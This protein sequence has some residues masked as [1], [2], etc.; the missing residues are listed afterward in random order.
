MVLKTRHDEKV[1]FDFLRNKEIILVGPA[2]YLTDKCQGD[3]IDAYDLIVR[4]NFSV[5]VKD[6]IKQDFGKRTDVLYKRLLK[7]IEGQGDYYPRPEEIK[8]WKDIGIK[9][10]VIIATDRMQKTNDFGKMAEKVLPWTVT[11]SVKGQIKKEINNKRVFAGLIS[12]V[13][14]LKAPVKSLTITNCTFY[15]TGYY[16]GYRGLEGEN[17]TEN[18]D[19]SDFSVLDQLRFLNNLRKKDKRLIFDDYLEEIVREKL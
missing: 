13:H 1:F 18:T 9:W 19:R 10:V 17:A 15:D 8:M 4:M 14:I 2:N 5:P 6:E 7:Q 3:I 11:G 16:E 12:V